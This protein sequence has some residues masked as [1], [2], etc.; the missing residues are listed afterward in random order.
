MNSG[1]RNAKQLV[2]WMA[3][4]LLLLILFQNLKTT[5]FETEIPYS[6]FKHKLRSGQ[7][8]EV[9]MRPDLIRG[10]FKEAER[11]PQ[12]QKTKRFRT[13]PL[14]DPDL[15]KDMDASSL[16]V[17]KGEQDKTWVTAVLINLG[18][19]ILFFILWWVF[20][21]RQ[22]QMGGKQAMSFGRSKAKLHK[23]D[24]KKQT[25]FKDVAG[26]D[27]AKEELEEIVA[28]LKDPAKFQ[29]LGGKIP[30]GVLLLGPPGTGKTLL[31]RAVAG[32]A[33]V[34][35][36]SA[37]GSEFVEMFVGVGASRVRDLFEQAKKSAPAVIFIDELDAV[38][39]SR[40]A[41]IGGGHDEREQTLNQI[42]VEL[43]GFEG[44]EGVI[45]I[46]ATNRPDVLDPALLRPGRFDR[47]VMV[48]PPDKVGR[49][50]ILE[51]HSKGVKLGKDI[52]LQ[53]LA[54]RTPGFVGADLAN[55]IN[56][57]A[58]LAA[59]RDRDDVS[60]AEMEEAIDRVMAGPSRKSRGISE[61][62]K[63]VIA[64]HE[65]GHTLVAKLIPGT[66]PVHKVSI[67]PRGPAL[68]YTLQLPLEDTYLTT[69]TDITNRLCVLMGGRVAEEIVF[70]EITTG[71]TDDLNKA[72]AYARKMIME[73]GMN[74]KLGPIAYKK[75]AGQVF[76]G[77]DIVE[78]QGFS[79][80]TAELIDNEVKRIIKET[81]AKVKGMLDKNRDLLETIATRLIEKEV[82]EGDELDAIL[83]GA[84]A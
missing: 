51:I 36:Y 31:A 47:H 61:K 39:R 71:A 32:E 44:K 66:D 73:F 74:E 13:F 49:E 20:V 15:V 1:K 43:D 40:F 81:Y 5:Q 79:E 3:A 59:R 76:L 8:S 28:F 34:P 62:E 12:G 80:A 23:N 38:G 26:V 50:Q 24:K 77:R 7:I 52:D 55:L 46:A 21:I 33:D 54:R 56:E 27:E 4:F 75:E 11:G 83:A 60:M 42:L 72:T 2:L 37:S 9:T 57:A 35:F 6:S 67:I 10:L 30:K 17:Y 78:G 48:S 16:S 22:V 18:W 45:L 19:V 82:V 53:V 65:S 25:T 41:G 84:K 63:K 69:K 58:L 14:P 70:G 64:Y 68:G 29:R